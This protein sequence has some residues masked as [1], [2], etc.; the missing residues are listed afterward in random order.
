VIQLSQCHR[1]RSPSLAL[2]L[3]A[4]GQI[5]PSDGPGKDSDIHLAP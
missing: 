2:P 5:K 4:G 1:K 3:L